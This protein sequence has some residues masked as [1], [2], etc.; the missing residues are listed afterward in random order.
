MFI[1]L[2]A[3][4]ASQPRTDGLKDST[5]IDDPPRYGKDANEALLMWQRSMTLSEGESLSGLLKTTKGL[6]VKR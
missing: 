2:Y 1:G 6:D 4:I 5:L 3:Q